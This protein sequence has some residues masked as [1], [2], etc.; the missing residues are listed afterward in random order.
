MT[1]N[2][3]VGKRLS[4]QWLSADPSAGGFLTVPNVT[5]EQRRV[6]HHEVKMMAVSTCFY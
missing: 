6:V 1:S 5:V 2:T 3:S 4:R